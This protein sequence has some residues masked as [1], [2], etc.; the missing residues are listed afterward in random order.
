[1]R[2]IYER[3]LHREMR[4]WIDK[5]V[6]VVLTGMRQV[7]KTTIM[8]MLFDEIKSDNKVFLDLENPLVRRAFTEKDYDNIWANLKNYGIT[9]DKKAYIFLDELQRMPEAVRVAKYLFDHYKVQFFV[10]GS[11]SFYLKNLFP[12]SLA[13]RKKIFELFPLDFEEFLWFKGINKDF[14]DDFS[15]KEKSKSP[16]SYEKVIKLYEEYLEYG[17][18]PRVAVSKTNADKKAIIEEIYTSY[19][20]KDV[21]SLADFKDIQ[22]LQDCMLL[23]AQR[24]GSKL[25]LSRLASE[26]GISRETVYSY[27][28]FLQSTYFISLIP[29]YSRSPDIEVS[30]AKKVYLC[31]TGIL[32]LLAKVSSGAVLENAV[33]NS[34]KKRGPV[35]YYQ[36]RSGGELDFVLKDE[37]LAIEVKETAT[38]QD[39]KRTF[40]ISADLKLKQG[41]VATKKFNDGKGFVLATDV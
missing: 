13:G 35:A 16:I 28:S 17:G 32:N 2:Q 33:F 8:R 37:G 21:R 39:L 23:L 30:G 12:E 1:M 20:E 19:F 31:D 36:R 14:Q 34:L 15:F 6:I 29:P 27:L 40:E 24:V 7:G 25:N 18:F 9:K 5:P 4:G 22:R 10:T 41:Y 26:I 11:S 3:K 38:D